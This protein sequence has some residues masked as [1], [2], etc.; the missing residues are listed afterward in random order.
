M[1]RTYIESVM[2][3][4]EKVE[5][6]DDREPELLE[7]PEDNA[8]VKAIARKQRYAFD[9][10]GKKYSANKLY[11]YRDGLFEAALHRFT[12]D[13]TLISY[14]EDVR[15]WGGAFAVYRGLTELLPYKRLFNSPISEASIV[16]SAVGYAMSGG[17]A[18]VELMYCDFMGKGR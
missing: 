13:P 1:D 15:D 6:F 3:S 5:S 11:A 4:N 10:N 8:R 2:F 12:T 18:M 7:K 14:G 17:R 9:E 16:G